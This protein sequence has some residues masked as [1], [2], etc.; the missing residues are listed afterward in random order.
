MKRRRRA[1]VRSRQPLPN[2]SVRA[3][4]RSRRRPEKKGFA[5]EEDQEKRS[6]NADRFMYKKMPSRTGEREGEAM[7]NQRIERRGAILRAAL[8]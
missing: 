7:N 3:A 8:P 5:K 4:L 6:G 2:A 1:G